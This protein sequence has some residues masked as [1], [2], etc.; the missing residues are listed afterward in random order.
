MQSRD[1]V[2]PRGCAHIF[3]QNRPSNRQLHKVTKALSHRFVWL[4]GMFR[5]VF[6]HFQVIIQQLR[7]NGPE[8]MIYPGGSRDHAPRRATHLIRPSPILR[9]NSTLFAAKHA[10]A[11]ALTIISFT[12][13]SHTQMR[14]HTRLPFVSCCAGMLVYALLLG[15][16]LD[17]AHPSLTRKPRHQMSPASA[18]GS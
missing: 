18:P 7:L 17:R 11:L 6:V 1:R 16:I 15:A 14:Y 12:A 4:F 8:H 5:P 2:R 13:Q 10:L 9:Q 3:L